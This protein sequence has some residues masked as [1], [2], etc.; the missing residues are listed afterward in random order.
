M[1]ITLRK[2][3]ETDLEVF[4]KNQADIEAIFMAAFTSEDPYDKEAYLKKWTRLMSV[5]SVNMQTI[6]VEDVV[7]GCVVK[8]VM[9]GDSDITYA[10]DKKFWGKGITTEAVK[11]FLKVETNRPLFGRVVNDN[12]GSQKVLEKNG[13]IKIGTNTD[14]ANG[15]GKE[16]EEYIYKLYV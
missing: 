13:F 16:I 5:D 8:F 3:I 2:S 7:V 9:G 15:R 4:Y 14:F 6:L 11:K 10:L 12:Y 1:N